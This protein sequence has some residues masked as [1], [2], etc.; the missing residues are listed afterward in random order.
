MNTCLGIRLPLVLALML[1]S[2]VL[3][4]CFG[5]GGQPLD[6]GDP[7]V[8]GAPDPDPD[9]VTTTLVI[10]TLEFPDWYTTLTLAPTLEV[11]GELASVLWDFGAGAM[12]TTSTDLTPLLT[13]QDPGDSAGSLVLTDTAGGRLERR[14]TYRVLAPTLP[15]IE[16]PEPMGLTGWEG[17]PLQFSVSVAG[18]PV[19]SWAWSFGD[20]ATPAQSS[21]AR[22]IVRLGRVGSYPGQVTVCNAFGCVTRSFMFGVQEPVL[23]WEATPFASNGTNPLLRS[24]PDGRVLLVYEEPHKIPREDCEDC[25]PRNGTSIRLGLGTWSEADSALTWELRELTPP[26]LSTP[27]RDVVL[28]GDRLILCA[29]PGGFTRPSLDLFITPI[30]GGAMQQVTFE[31]LALRGSILRDP[32]MAIHDGELLLACSRLD[33]SDWQASL[34]AAPLSALAGELPQLQLDLTTATKKSVNAVDLQVS[35]G[36]AFLAWTKG[37]GVQIKY[38]GTLAVGRR[39]AL[40]GWVTANLDQSARNCD[41][42]RFVPTM[43]GLHLLYTSYQAL[44]VESNGYGERWT[45]PGA[46]RLR[47]AWT[48]QRDFQSAGAWET[49]FYGEADY[50]VSVQADLFRGM[51]L[52]TGARAFPS[53]RVT[54]LAI[55]QGFD[56]AG[57]AIPWR[58]SFQAEAQAGRGCWKIAMAAAHD[59]AVVALVDYMDSYWP[60]C[61]GHSSGPCYEMLNEPVLKV[62]VLRP[63]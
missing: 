36:Q 34:M 10:T 31:G 9:P 56:L 12:P 8:P 6:P 21:E 40:G 60:F 45:V 55:T 35:E 18:P 1:T 5:T 46:P 29:A 61:G 42:V 23:Q 17:G 58:T 49:G 63:Q 15:Q 37:E 44:Y 20:G 50:L 4:G 24:V 52:I 2:V 28:D 19:V 39:T 53:F 33:G 26:A 13:L 48:S 22:P 32:R 43:T 25:E 54:T 16:E 59:V 11:E 62:G 30:D 14:F 27:G 47:E 38:P 57:G 3:L 41:Q 51:P 7:Q